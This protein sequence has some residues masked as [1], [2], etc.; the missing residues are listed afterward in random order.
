[1]SMTPSTDRSFVQRWKDFWFTPRDPTTLGFMRIVT[2]LLVLY[3]HLAYSVDLQAF[4]GKF[5]WYGHQYIDRE[6]REYPSHVT[7]FMNWDESSDALTRVPEYPHRRA[8]V[9]NFIRNLPE[10]SAERNR[11]MAFFTRVADEGNPFLSRASLNLVLRLYGVADNQRELI[12]TNGLEKGKQWY[13]VDRGGIEFRDEQPTDAKFETI[14]PDVFLVMTPDNRAKFAAELRALIAVL[15]RKPVEAQYVIGHLV[16]LDQAHRRM[17]VQFLTSLPDDAGERNRLIDYLDYWN[18]DERKMFRHGQ[19]IFSVWFH[20]TDPTQMALF[21]G[22]ILFIIFLFTI[23]FCT[24]VTSV[25]TWIAVVGYI[26]RTN[27]ILFGMDTM[28]NILLIYLMIGNSGAALSVDRLMA[29]YR[30]ARASLRRSGTIDEPT[31]AFLEQAPPSAG[32][33]FG[34]RMIQ[35][36][37]CFIYM[38]AGLSKL[39]G[40]GWWNGSAFWDVMINPEFTLM[41]YRFFEDMVRSIAEIKP[42]YYTITMFGVWF[43]WGLEI[44]FPFLVWTRLRPLMLWMAVLLHAGI[45][46]LM[47]L[48]LFELL[49]MTMLLVYLPPG[50]IRDR[51]RGSGLPKLSFGYDSGDPKEQRAAALVAAMDV[52]GQVK[53]EAGKK[54]PLS[55]STIFSSVRLLS[56]LRFLLFVPGLATLLGQLFSPSTI[57]PSRLS[58]AGPKAPA[59][60]S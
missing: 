23:G 16:D 56:A 30:A 32:A 41:K 51:L 57:S 11:S 37:F 8:A 42:L 27:Q 55:A 29:R 4:F 12:L 50:V 58:Q 3:T 40:P 26:H 60:A 44:S 36:H 49:M 1:M 2:G 47:G 31:Q 25:L 19:P 45:G 14:F 22:A 54:N 21:H 46:M 48:N 34:I 24:R 18:N 39:K 33:N 52:D 10:T 15:P 9:I 5:G 38:A 17:F 7:S 35:V 53:F 59:A 20:V 6:R 28:M 43:T 13:V